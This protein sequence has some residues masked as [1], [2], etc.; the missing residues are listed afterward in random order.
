MKNHITKTDFKGWYPEHQ[1]AMEI[2]KLR[3]IIYDYKRNDFQ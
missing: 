1:I 3:R 2:I